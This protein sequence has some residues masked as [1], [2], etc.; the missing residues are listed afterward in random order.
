MFGIDI[1]LTGRVVLA[2]PGLSADK[3]NM[4]VCM[5]ACQNVPY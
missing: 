5:K 3:L 4:I 2:I 1:V